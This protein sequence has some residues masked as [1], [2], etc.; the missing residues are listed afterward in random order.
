MNGLLIVL[1]GL[2]RIFRLGTKDL[3]QWRKKE[4]KKGKLKKF[5]AMFS[6]FAIGCSK[7]FMLTGCP[8]P[9]P[10][11]DFN[12]TIGSADSDQLEYE[13]DGAASRLKL[14]PIEYYVDNF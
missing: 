13:T 2:M 12:Y 7:L 3:T 5:L 9:V 4:M 14:Y 6:S 10:V 8:E 1:A 11:P